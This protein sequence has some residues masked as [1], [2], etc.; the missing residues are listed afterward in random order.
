M[1]KENYY[2]LMAYNLASFKQMTYQ[3]TKDFNLIVTF[4]SIIT[5]ILLIIEFAFIFK[6]QPYDI[7]NNNF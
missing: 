6:L 1:K 7:K 4:S 5:I 2:K 3:I